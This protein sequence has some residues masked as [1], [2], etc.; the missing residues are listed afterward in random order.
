MAKPSGGVGAFL[1]ALIAPGKGQ[2]RPRAPADT[3]LFTGN[4]SDTPP[5]LGSSQRDVTAL[6]RV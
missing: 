2:P 6:P 5:W 4:P 3:Y 1:P